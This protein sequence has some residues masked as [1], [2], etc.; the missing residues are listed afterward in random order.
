[1]ASLWS[2]FSLR[3]RIMAG[4][5]SL[6]LLFL[7][8]MGVGQY[9]L[10]VT[11]SV[12]SQERLLG[13]LMK[14]I[15]EA[16][17]QVRDYRLLNQ[18]SQAMRFREIVVRIRQ[19]LTAYLG[20]HGGDLATEQQTALSANLDQFQALFAK[21]EANR[22]SQRELSAK[23][24]AVAAQVRKTVEEGFRQEISRLHNMAAIQGDTL[25]PNLVETLA[26][27]NQFMEVFLAGQVSES[28]YLL[29]KDATARKD[30]DT[31]YQEAQEALV[32]LGRIVEFA[33]AEPGGEVFAARIKELEK[34]RLEYLANVKALFEL[35]DNDEALTAS[36]GA[37]G[38]QAAQALERIAGALQEKAGALRQRT[39]YILLG[40]LAFGLLAGLLAAW[41]MTRNISLPLNRAIEGLNAGADGVAGASGQIS[42]SSQEMASGASEQ[43]ASLEETSASLEELAS[44]TRQNA[45]H[46]GQADA[47]SRQAGQVIEGATQ[48][49]GQLTEHMHQIGGASEQIR[50]IIKTIDEIAFQ[51]NLLAL[52]AAV[53]AARAGEAG[54]GFAVVADEVRNLAM[55]ASEAAKN[56]AGLIEDAVSK[57]KQGNTLVEG[58]NQAFQEIVRTTSQ[59]AALVAEIAAASSE[60][61]QGIDQ[62]NKAVAEM[63]RV[64]QQN[65][66]NAEESAASSAELLGQADHLRQM[67]L[68]LL[69]LVKG[70]GRQIQSAGGHPEPTALLP[71]PEDESL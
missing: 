6:L 36:V 61:A 33:K 64:V 18:D 13:Q 16:N 31:R 32:N 57:I 48:S 8:G 7:L 10:S 40:L 11:A 44:M 1:M 23:T 46:A 3:L 25:S 17:V 14:D 50:K 43:A 39:G 56:T 70:A 24:T 67:V 55:R 51:T 58:T 71:Q 47:L 26:Q 9:G 28:L 49:M 54:A 60:Q 29:Y 62:V 19:G 15:L 66:A 22:K 63:D 21:L 30:V 27:A 42:R 68:S 5:G 59:V 53:E 38:V 65:A 20:E 2:R 12:S 69:E 45:D 35:R 34:V 52:N 41:G 4:F 37:Q